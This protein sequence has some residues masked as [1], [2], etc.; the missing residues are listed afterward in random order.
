MDDTNQQPAPETTT[1]GGVSG[2][3]H[4]EAPS[5][6][7]S[8]GL[9]E[10][11]EDLGA[12]RELLERVHR[13]HHPQIE[14]LVRW[15][16]DGGDCRH[17]IDVALRSAPGRSDRAL[18]LGERVGDQLR[19]S[20]VPVGPDPVL[21]A[22]DLIVGRRPLDA[23]LQEVVGA[24]GRLGVPVW[25]TVHF[26]ADYGQRF[27]A[28]VAAT[29]FDTFRRAVESAAA[30]ERPCVWDCEPDDDATYRM[31]DVGEGLALAGRHA[32]IGAC[33]VTPLH[34]DDGGSA[35]A[36]V[37]WAET[38]ELLAHPAVESLHERVTPLAAV[39]FAQQRSRDAVAWSEDHDP[40]TGLLNRP[41]F[42]AQLRTPAAQRHCA[43]ACVDIDDFRGVNER[44]GASA[45]D[46]LLVEVGQRLR[47]IMRPGDRAARV[48]GD[49]FAV[50]YT[51]LP[52]ADA[53]VAIATRLQALFDA[54]VNLSGALTAVSVSTGI[55]SSTPELAG[56]RLFDAAERA[57]L[58]V[59][60]SQRG[61]WHAH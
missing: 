53:A 3:V 4:I 17:G 12:V 25:A 49:R 22:L 56:V 36:L 29:G 27:R 58:A 16:A 54:P 18:V 50:L 19:F 23:V 59:K 26:D 28:V 7:I 31:S 20:L 52:T 51:D 11:A 8:A 24:F 46:H 34:D 1:Y 2:I 9:L 60:A 45:G 37:V 15:L 10:A 48:S 38:V 39:A 6:P 35:A 30:S 43:I 32:G 33:R 41:A 55:A 44:H 47:E 61:S 21:P 13:D 14:R 42:L 40:L 57:M 5:P